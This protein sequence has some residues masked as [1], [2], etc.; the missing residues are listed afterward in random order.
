MTW[1]RALL[2]ASAA[3]FAS[4]ASFVA[5]PN[6]APASDPNAAWGRVLER[7]VDE[8]GRV[9]FDA[10][11]ADSA[12]LDAFV[13]HVARPSEQLEDCEQALVCW[14]NA[15]NALAMYNVLHAGVV[16]EQKVRFFYL[17]ELLVFGERLSLYEFEK[18]VIRRNRDPRLHFALNCMVRDCPRLAREPYSYERL[19][20]QLDAAAREFIND[21]RRVR[22][23]RE[24]G[25]LL[26]SPIFDWYEE[27]FRESAPSLIEFVARYRDLGEP[28]P[29]RVEFLDYDWTLNAQPTA[30]P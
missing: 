21:E 20:R 8:Q 25:V 18:D 23:D 30:T 5:P 24:R 4:C 19:E 11:R 27:D 15:Y 22:V 13:A 14:I 10:L 26:L 2:I 9:A 17:R 12:D 6:V 29:T 3:L 28:R 7:F 1:I 16:P